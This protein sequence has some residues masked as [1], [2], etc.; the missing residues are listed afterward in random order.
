MILIIR[1]LGQMRKRYAIQFNVFYGAFLT[2]YLAKDKYRNYIL[3]VASIVR[4]HIV[5]GQTAL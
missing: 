3:L 5:G 2:Y 1:K 4:W